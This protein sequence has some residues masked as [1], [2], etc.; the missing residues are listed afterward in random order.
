MDSTHTMKDERGVTHFFCKHHSLTKKEIVQ[1]KYKKLLP[2]FLIFIFIF[3][4]PLVRQNF[5]N[6]DW[7][8]YM[9]DF[10]GVFF[11]IFGLFKLVDL[12]GFVVGFQNYDFIAKRFSTYGYAYP[13][14]EIILGAMYLLG[15]MFLVQN[16][17]VLILSAVGTITAYAYI[18]NDED[19]RCV[20]LGTLF[21]LP[22]TVVTFLENALMFLMAL[23]MVSFI[24]FM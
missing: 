9:M 1:E 24:L 19:I 10:M 17:L 23:S 18:D 7:M 2:L 16:L 5:S 21:D 6:F 8:L 15:F 4:L 20:C 14:I 12:K 22:M 13:F 3:L 11:I